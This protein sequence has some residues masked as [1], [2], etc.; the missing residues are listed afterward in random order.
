VDPLL[1]GNG[2]WNF[3]MPAYVAA[4]QYLMR[5]ELIGMDF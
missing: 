2:W 4:G 5:V 3:T 1:A